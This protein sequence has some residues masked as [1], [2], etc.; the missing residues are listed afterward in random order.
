MLH[1][2]VVVVPISKNKPPVRI[3]APVPDHMRDA[4][5]SCGWKEEESDP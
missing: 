5:R 3:T 1:A 4:L 2:R